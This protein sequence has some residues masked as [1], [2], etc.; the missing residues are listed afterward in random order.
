MTIDEQ[1]VALLERAKD[2]IQ[3][4]MEQEN[5]NASGRSSRS[6]R[7]EQYDG[8]VRL[9]YGGADTAPLGTLEV[10]RPGGNVPGGFVTTKA[11]VR[12]VS[13][14][15]KAILIQWAKDKGIADFGWGRATMLGRRIAEQG[16]LRHMNPVDVY[17]SIVMETAER[18]KDGL[19]SVFTMSIHETI[20][21]K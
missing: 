11:G 15:F 10:G 13:K 8:G 7:V 16:T 2:D 12:D 4:M 21:A 20:R 1:I 14:T 19:R 6:F 17:T 5:I 9:V 3:T 18:V